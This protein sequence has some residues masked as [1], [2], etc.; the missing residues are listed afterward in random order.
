VKHRLT[1][2]R[3]T[4]LALLAASILGL[5]HAAH[6]Q[7]MSTRLQSGDANDPSADK[8]KWS[9]KEGRLFGSRAKSLGYY[10]TASGVGENYGPAKA[11]GSA[12]GQFGL[13][14][15]QTLSEEIFEVPATEADTSVPAFAWT[16]GDVGMDDAFSVKNRV[17]DGETLD[18]TVYGHVDADIESATANWFEGWITA[19]VGITGAYGSD[20]LRW[21]EGD[22]GVGVSR[23]DWVLRGASPTS[24]PISIYTDIETRAKGCD[25]YLVSQTCRSS[26]K[27]KMVVDR[28]EVNSGH[29]IK[30]AS[31]KLVKVDAGGYVYE[32]TLAE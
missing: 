31:G 5:S 7:F 8:D 23:I 21:H 1:A 19:S 28:V 4:S 18:I 3:S 6:A 11:K 2:L 13:L 27:L 14:D 29:R 16:M 12:V 10:E 24:N 30:A 9:L 25:S 32:A 20:Y 17:V 22:F 26:A 15:L